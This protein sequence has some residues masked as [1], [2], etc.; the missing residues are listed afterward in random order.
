MF[1]KVKLHIILC[2]IAIIWIVYADSV[3][4]KPINWYPSFTSYHK[5][6]FGTF[7][8]RETL[9]TF[10]SKTD[11]KEIRQSP[12]VQL[13]DSTLIGTYF[14]VNDYINFGNEEFNELLKFVKRGNDVFISTNGAQVDTLNL[15]TETIV[16]FNT[17]EKLK[18]KLL[19]PNL[20]TTSVLIKNELSKIGFKKIDT[21]KTEVLGKIQI[22][23][24]NQI[25]VK[26]EVN[27]VRQKFGKGYFYFHLHPYSFTNYYMLKDSNN[28]YTASVLSYLDEKKPILW[29][30]Y[31]KTGKSKIST[32]MHYV[33]SSKNLKWAYY[34]ALFA[35]LIFV[36]FQG[37]RNQRFIPIIT[38][39]KNQTINFAKTISNLYLEKND[40]KS[41][42][43]K[44]IFFFLS[45]IRI[46]F[47]ITVDSYNSSFYNLL[48][49]KSGNSK[50][51]IEKLFFLIKKINEQSTITKEQLLELNTK[52]EHFKAKHQST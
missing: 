36:L 5:I 24:E 20:D 30:T 11:L 52:I 18:L 14:F 29:D 43:G 16:T 13:Q 47:N 39:L 19:N 25:L 15:E 50:E 26:E 49:A 23:K 10:L 35:L 37:K 45:Y 33:L 28:V 22:F 34:T 41:V 6:P 12:Y 38:P 8:L 4:K 1:K 3:R 2:L 51:Q 7:V 31:Y 9:P 44:S 42:A 46:Q 21:L 17:N 48:S 27:F 32:P 40:H